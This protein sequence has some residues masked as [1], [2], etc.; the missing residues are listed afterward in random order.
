M[1]FGSQDRLKLFLKYYGT[2]L[3]PPVYGR[4]S[5]PFRIGGSVVNRPQFNRVCHVKEL[6]LN[7]F[8]KSLLLFALNWLDAQLTILWVRLSVATEGNGV[9]ERVLKFGEAPFLTAKLAVGALAA[10]VLYR[11]AHLPMARR[12]MRLVLGIYCATMCIHVATGFSA[13]GWRAPE[14]V[15]AYFASLPKAIFALFS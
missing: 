4:T 8:A 3:V 6:K 15:V 2:S 11:Y 1:V 12:G 7:L 14:I 13:L 5:G 9:M 10:Y